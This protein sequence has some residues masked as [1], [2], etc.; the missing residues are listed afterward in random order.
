MLNRETMINWAGGLIGFINGDLNGSDLAGGNTDFPPLPFQRRS[1]EHYESL[2]ARAAKDVRWLI[3]QEID[4]AIRRGVGEKWLADDDVVTDTNFAFLPLDAAL[5]FSFSAGKNSGA[6]RRLEL[7]GPR[8]RS[9]DAYV[10]ITIA[11]LMTTDCPVQVRACALD[12]CERLF[13]RELGKKGRPKECCS[14]AHE[15]TRRTRRARIDRAL[16]DLPYSKRSRLARSLE[17]VSDPKRQTQMK[18]EFLR[19]HGDTRRHNV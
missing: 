19:K 17:G 18:V 12:T 1:A 15:N 14:A 4:D 13:V 3:T 9:A 5:G 16:A 6:S 11:E 8:V 2:R 10:A 7:W